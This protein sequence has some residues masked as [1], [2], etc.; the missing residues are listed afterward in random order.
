MKHVSVH[1]LMI[2]GCGYV[3]EKLAQAA[4][5]RGMQVTAVVR[6]EMHAQAL[7]N[8][9]ISAIVAATPLEIP[10]AL[11]AEC[12][13]VVD[14]IPLTMG[15]DGEP[16]APQLDWLSQL[17]PRLP[18]ILWAGYLSSTSVYGDAK[19]E[20]VDESWRCDPSSVRGQQ[21]LLVE[22]GW[23]QSGLPAEVF[24]LSGIYGPDRN[25]LAKL[26][27]GNYPVID[28]DP[29][30]WSNR[31]HVFDIVDTLLA[32]MGNPCAG[33]VV[34]VTD[35]LPL[36]HADYVAEVAGYFEIPLPIHYT[37]EEAELRLPERMLEFF[38]D[39][40]RLSNKK[41]HETLLPVLRYPTFR[42]ALQ[43]W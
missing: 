15:R 7:Q 23:L 27:Q 18:H 39:N 14:S 37:A 33:R 32:A 5:A 36:S 40:K 1:A 43:E 3:G 24:R 26:R 12:D 16:W 19:G 22:K 31:I 29:P 34:N 8:R 21:R 13:G 9:G 41:L 25:I 10:T 35:D 4:M 6:G 11:L 28:W 17:A 42:V 30:H 20:W 38:R 2:L